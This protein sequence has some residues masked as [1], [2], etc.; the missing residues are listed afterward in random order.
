[1]LVVSLVILG[2]ASLATYFSFNFQDDVFQAAMAFTAILFAIL[3][4]IIA[5]WS[6]KLILLG[7][8]PFTFDRLNNWIIKK[9]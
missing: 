7:A 2:I 4:L 1:M 8:T 9:S 3:A 6:M 5:P